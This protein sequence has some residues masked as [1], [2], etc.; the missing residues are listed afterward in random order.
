MSL[1]SWDK[2]MLSIS[3]RQL[4]ELVKAG[5]WG[6]E[7]DYRLFEGQSIDW[8]KLIF[9]SDQQTVVGIVSDALTMMPI[10]LRPPKNKYFL[11][12]KKT[13][14]IE[15]ENVKMYD[16]VPTLIEEIGKQG[17]KTWLLKGQGVGLCY[18]NPYRRT[19][20]DVDLFVGFSVSDYHHAKKVLVNVGAKTTDIEDK[21]QHSEYLWHDIIVELHGKVRM[22]IC[23]TFD[24]RFPEWMERCMT[25]NESVRKKAGGTHIIYLPPYRF[26]AIFIFAHAMNHY[27]TSGVGVR[28]LCDWMCYLTKNHEKINLP[29]LEIDLNELGLTKFWKMFG[30]MAVHCLGMKKE[31]MPL[32]DDAFEGK[33]ERLLHH[34][35][36][37]GN[38]GYVQRK[39]QQ[40][41]GNRILKKLKTFYGQLFVYW[42]NIWVFPKETL[43][44]FIFFVTKGV[45]KL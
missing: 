24:E 34:V 25:E 10:T 8:D 11:F 45:R 4:I 1:P 26:D 33:D 18:R 23:K 28:Q 19:S 44:C 13:G 39:K 20:G 40:V 12:I 30:A 42:D 22:K 43:Y 6:T 32:Y 2:D 31:L 38:F 29:Q 37:T 16:M 35:F 36:T 9:L 21:R 15:E 27:M 14:E 3:E 7:V 5:L 17:I 41:G